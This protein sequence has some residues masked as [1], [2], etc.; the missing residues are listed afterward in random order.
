MKK[1][2]RDNI[3]FFPDVERRLAEKG[4]EALQ[5]KRYRDAIELLEQGY[6]LDPADTDIKAAL[7][8]AYFEAG[9]LKKAKSLCK[10]MLLAG[11]GDYFQLVEMYMA[12]LIQL[13]EY[14]EITSV[15]EA[16]F[17]EGEVPAEKREHFQTIL[18]FCKR[19]ADNE[20]LPSA[21]RETEDGQEEEET[22]RPGEIDFFKV[23]DLKDQV[24]I[25]GK[26]ASQNIQ[27][28]VPEIFR[29][30]ASEKGH[31]F[32]KTILLNVLK[33]QSVDSEIIVKK[34]GVVQT[35]NPVRMSALHSLPL[36]L[37]ASGILA[38]ELEHSDP[39]L[40][41]NV[42]SLM[43]RHFFASYPI[44][45]D[46]K[47]PSAWAAAFHWIG[48]SYLGGSPDLGEMA[49]IYKVKEEK[50]ETAVNWIQKVEE[51]SYPII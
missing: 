21:N 45:L 43:Q 9:A 4:I 44:E 48:L 37:E 22:I 2:G 38:G 24:M 26:L 7:V 15:L 31:P 17:D 5:E 49:R 50:V 42:L 20:P 1:K 8:L 28:L 6:E 32:F 39:V 13:H 3:V 34:F 23:N 12:I 29:F 41:E 46:P 51:I 18:Q 16:L 27:P 25:A 11:T 40:L 35:V 10:E 47:L 19:M 36:E 33:E 30:L 14:R